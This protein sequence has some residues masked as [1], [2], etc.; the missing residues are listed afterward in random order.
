MNNCY[1]EVAK[2]NKYGFLTGNAIKIIAAISM[3]I[4]H[5]YKVILVPLMPNGWLSGF[6][7]PAFSQSQI[8]FLEKLINYLFTG[9]GR[10]AFPLFCFLLAEGFYYTKNKK[11]Y[12][13]LMA[14]FALISE[15]PFDLAIWQN[16]SKAMGTF[17]FYFGYQN[18]YFTLFLGLCA[19]WCVDNVK[20]KSDKYITKIIS[21]LL[22]TAC[23]LVLC[24]VSA[25]IC[26]D[27]QYRGILFI[28]GFYVMR[29]NRVLQIILFLLIYSLLYRTI[30]SIFIILSSLILL[31][32]NGKRGNL[33]LKY[34]FYIFYPAHLFLIY[35]MTLIY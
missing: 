8:G 18:V 32:Y 15:I 14:A 11:R 22:K 10:I 16:I 19:L 34:F 25:Y 6:I 5:F 31:L 7:S 12:F 30:P 24:G 23:V 29:K 20:I 13:A 35:L 26:A 27:Y 28:V 1:V 3:F 33:N 9:A 2:E 21:I 4:D 17:P